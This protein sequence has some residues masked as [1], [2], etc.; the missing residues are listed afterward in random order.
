M[1]VN[2]KI[3]LLIGI[4]V[5]SSCAKRLTETDLPKVNREKT[6][7]LLNVLDSLST[8]RPQTFYSKITTKYSDTT[9]N[10]S[11]KTSV[12]MI[13]DSAL[14]AIVTYAAI[15]VVNALVTP[16]SLKL[17]NKK[18]K[19]LVFTD[20]EFIKSNFGV[21]FSFKNIEEMLL[22]IPLDY[23]TTQKYFQIHDPYRHII[24]SHRK[25]RI[26]KN[27]RLLRKDDNIAIQYFIHPNLKQLN[28]LEIISVGDTTSVTIDYKTWQLVNGFNVPNEVIIRIRTPK[29]NILIELSYEKVSVNE[30]MELYFIIPEGY[31]ECK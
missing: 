13:A 9:R 17:V 16:D 27:E 19:C 3:A 26:R 7:D 10:I 31:E 1:K 8:T 4:V 21:D 28:G 23:D 15:P 11:V 24:S 2:C 20:L 25:R 30:P 18:D 29:N 5:L 22:G 14:N 12:R 6:Q